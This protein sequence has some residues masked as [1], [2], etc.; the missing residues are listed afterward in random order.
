MIPPAIARSRVAIEECWSRRY[1][2]QA[3]QS[4]CTVLPQG[5]L[6]RFLYSA[7]AIVSAFFLVAEEPIGDGLSDADAYHL[8]GMY[9]IRSKSEPYQWR[10][11]GRWAGRVATWW[12]CARSVSDLLAT[13]LERAGTGDRRDCLEAARRSHVCWEAAF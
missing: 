12:P 1:Q 2:C 4:V 11:I 6:P 8:Q 3:C 5:V 9:S 13:L 10:S 7:L